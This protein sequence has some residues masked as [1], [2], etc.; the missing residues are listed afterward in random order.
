M[1]DQGGSGTERPRNLRVVLYSH[2]TMGIGHLRRNLLI[3]EALASGPSHADILL[4][5]GAREAS[6][7]GLP[8][9][10]DCLT[11]PSL[12]KDDSGKYRPLRLNLPLEE[13][14]ELR[15]RT[16]EAALDRFRPD[17]LIVDKVPLG[18]VN[19]L[20]PSLDRL[21]SS[22]LTRVILGLRDVLDDPA[23]VDR[24]WRQAGSEEAVRDYYDAI[25]IYGDSAVYDPVS[26]YGFTAEVAAKVRFTGYPDQ[27]KRTRFAETGGGE[28]LEGLLDSPGRLYLCMVG[29]GQ[30]GAD[31]AE[32]FSQV[33]FPPGTKG[34]LVS[35]PFMPPEVNHRLSLRAASNPHFIVLKFVTDSDALLRRADRVI[36]MG[37]YNTVCEVLAFEKVAMIVPRVR[38]RLEQ[39]IR[40][41]R[42]RD[43]GV[44]DVLVPDE[45]SPAALTEWLARDKAAPCV[46]DR[47]DMN[48]LRNLP[49]LLAEVLEAPSTKQRRTERDFQHVGW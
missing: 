11:L 25:W 16:I 7:F 43:L 24:E 20:V 18:A 33:N 31:L 22:G 27:R 37:G 21:R 48:G 17:A 15:S 30:D 40:A 14:I 3:A 4:I 1:I 35:G 36:A 44:L 39:M 2:D 12:F 23:T 28:T 32:A 29:G 38:P 49:G 45:L 5:A 19:E 47:I 34:V 41:E 6:A 26:E 46:R 42:M 9:G 10:V 8:P 13:L